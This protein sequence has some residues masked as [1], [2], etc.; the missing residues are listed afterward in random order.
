M[1]I[2]A[3]LDNEQKIIEI[4]ELDINTLVEGDIPNGTTGMIKIIDESNL[5][6]E[7][8]IWIPLENRFE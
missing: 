6:I 7:G 4:K 8:Q 2:Y 1:A 3:L 5:P